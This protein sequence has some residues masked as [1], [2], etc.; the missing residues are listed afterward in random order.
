MI[1]FEPGLWDRALGGVR[2]EDLLLV[3][4]GGCETL[5][6]YPYDLAP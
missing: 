5:T 3:T 2:F 6:D 4:D 1:A